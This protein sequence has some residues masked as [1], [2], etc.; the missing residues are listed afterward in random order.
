MKID[1]SNWTD[2]RIGDYFEKLDLK[3]RKINFNKIVDCSEYPSEE[4]S[5]PLVNAKHFNNGI[6]FY[7]RPEEWDSAEMTIDIVSNGAIATGDVFAQP[8][9]TG[10]LWDAYLIKCRYEIKSEYVLHFLACV[11]EKCVKQYFG[12]NDKCTWDKVKQKMIKLPVALNGE[13]D[14][15]YMETYMKRIIDESEKRI[16]CLKTGLSLENAFISRLF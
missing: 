8:Q 4:F 16:E 13:P 12:W 2:C 3:C 6:Q 10:V 11:I 14:W 1:T 15:E 7:G 9:R 5:L